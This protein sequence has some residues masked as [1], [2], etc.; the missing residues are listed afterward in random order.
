MT[1]RGSR[2]MDSR[3]RWIENVVDGSDRKDLKLTWSRAPER[4]Q[5]RLNFHFFWAMQLSNLTLTSRTSDPGDSTIFCPFASPHNL[6]FHRHRPRSPSTAKEKPGSPT[7]SL[8]FVIFPS[9]LEPSR[10]SRGQYPLRDACTR[11]TFGHR[12]IRLDVSV[13]TWTT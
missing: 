9:P 6:S 11:E 2:G 8:C 3:W 10:S 12:L 1:W 5:D 13:V 7:Q 4:P